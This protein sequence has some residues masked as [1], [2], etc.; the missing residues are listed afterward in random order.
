MTILKTPFT[1]GIVLLG[2]GSIGQ[3][4]A[5]ALVSKLNICR[6]QISVYAKD[7]YG[8]DIAKVLG[9]DFKLQTIT[10]DNFE[11]VLGSV[12]KRG[13]ILLNLAV[14]VSTCD[15]ICLCQKLGAHYI[16]TSIEPWPGGYDAG[17]RDVVE[18]TN[19]WLREQALKLAG[20]GKPTAVIAHGAN[21]GLISHLMKEA[22]LAFAD[23][24]DLDVSGFSWPHLG[25]ALGV[26]VIQV[27]ER[28]TQ[29]DDSHLEVGEFANTWSIHGFLSEVNQPAEFGWGSHEAAL[30]IGAQLHDFGCLSSAYWPR[31][32]RA[33]PTVQTWGPSGHAREAYLIT[34][35]ESISIA[36]HM[37]L[38]FQG[39]VIYRPTVYY[40]YVP[41]E[42]AR[43]SLTQWEISG[44][45]P[46]TKHS[47]ISYRS[48]RS[49]QDELGV[50]LCTQAGS[51]WYGSTLDIN[52]AHQ[53]LP[54]N[55][56]TSLQVVAGILGAIVWMIENPNEG[57]VEAEQMDHVRVMDVARPLLG[58]VQGTHTNWR[59]NH[60][61]SLRFE[62]FLKGF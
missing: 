55:S 29:K 46:P 28:D 50:L 62:E 26:E 9:F 30:P 43:Q 4:L 31:L 2:F 34:H 52:E 57:V 49:G 14:E 13:D 53:L 18:T 54:F 48:I 11:V 23:N 39:R 5:P 20:K 1:G 27:A 16:D 25:R 41:C 59:P 24:K 17:T 32:N 47:L 58:K 35:N 42:K 44:R 36:E 61:G 6:T 8:S 33:P 22:L 19:Y 60:S 15:L 3:G 7:D 12:L 38:V 21:P 40:A 45:S 10:K 56:A 37:S 51:F